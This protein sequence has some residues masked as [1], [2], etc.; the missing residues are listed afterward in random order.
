MPPGLHIHLKPIYLGISAITSSIVTVNA[1]IQI[2]VHLI[3]QCVMSRD[4]CMLRGISVVEFI[5]DDELFSW[6]DR[7]LGIYIYNG[8]EI[9]RRD[10]S[11]CI[12]L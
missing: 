9:I 6:N 4:E 7:W 10:C 11:F 12:K 5:E 2:I 3:F 8:L 1:A